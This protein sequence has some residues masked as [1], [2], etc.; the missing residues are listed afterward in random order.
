MV[1]R[2]LLL[3][4]L[5]ATLYGSWDLSFEQL[6]RTF[7]TGLY[8][9]STAGYTQKF[10]QGDKPFM[11]GYIRPAVSLQTSAVVNVAKAHIDFNP[12]SFVNFTV[13][14]AYTNRNI[15]EISNFNCNEVICRGELSRAF[16]GVRTAL[17]FKKVI[18]LAGV[19][20][21]RV[22]L[23][24]PSLLGFA[25]EL[26][27]LIASPGNDLLIQQTI[28]LGY[29]LTPKLM[30]GYLGQYNRMKNTGLESKM[31]MA[32]GQYSFKPK[33]KFSI[34]PGVFETRTGSKNLMFLSIIHWNFKQAPILAN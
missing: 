29:Q 19:K 34:G 5:P 14:K 10:W 33:W 15:S 21:T 32:L 27:S 17:S 16:Y 31:H 26:S 11:Y 8:L 13:G 18:F 23:K 9:K 24:E 12:I 25:D 6:V 30:L 2:A 3:F 4:L 22:Y 1:L 7:P 20:W 28:L